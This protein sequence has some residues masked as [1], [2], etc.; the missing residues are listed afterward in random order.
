MG[1]V[2]IAILG[3]TL[4]QQSYQSHQQFREGLKQDVLRLTGKVQDDLERLLA[5][6]VGLSTGDKVPFGDLV[7]GLAQGEPK[8]PEGYSTLLKRLHL[9]QGQYFDA[10][11]L[12]KANIDTFFVYKAH[13]RRLREIQDF[14]EANQRFLEDWDQ[15]NV[16]VRRAFME[17]EKL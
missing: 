14:L 13:S 16:N 12:Y 2:S 4:L 5:R 11:I 1:L 7:E 17:E 15:T 9:L 3:I 6:E 8:N 10:L